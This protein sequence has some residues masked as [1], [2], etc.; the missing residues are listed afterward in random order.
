MSTPTFSFVLEEEPEQDLLE[1]DPMM[2]WAS[3]SEPE[4]HHVN[5][6]ALRV[7]ED[8]D[9]DGLCL[10][11]TDNEGEPA[12][13]GA[14]SL[15]SLQ[16]LGWNSSFPHEFVGKLPRDLQVQ[17]INHRLQ[18]V[19][20]KEFT[21]IVEDS[22]FTNMTPGWRGILP[23]SQAAQFALNTLRDVY[24]HEVQVL[25]AEANGHA[26]TRISVPVEQPVTKKVGDV[27]R[28]GVEVVHCYGTTIDVGLYA[29][30]LICTNGMVRTGEAFKWTQKSGGTISH[31][32]NWLRQGMS[33]ALDEFTTLVERAQLMSN[34]PFNG[35]PVEVLRE[36]ARAMRL[37]QGYNTRLLEA[38]NEEPDP[39]SWGILNAFTRFASHGDIPESVSASIMRA[40]GNWTHSFDMCT[41]RLPRP[42]AVAS[43]AE[44]IE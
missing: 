26:R 33:A 6:G 7:I 18:A 35:N 40:A 32:F 9:R 20:A 17:I 12:T 14:V 41:A 34:T 42:M 24:G 23:Y 13:L 29:E 44:I 11:R 21:I 28:A 36:H 22:V 5:I 8:D 37:P 27:M 1:L 38:Y 30:R 10:Q 4:T 31:Q 3:W 25:K 43:G 15:G 2:P 19:P 39:T 16:Q